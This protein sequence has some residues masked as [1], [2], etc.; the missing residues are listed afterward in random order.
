[1]GYG[2]ETF[3]V[4]NMLRTE[5]HLRSLKWAADLGSQQIHFSKSDRGD[6]HRH[7]DVI[8]E[9]IN[10]YTA[11]TI[12]ATKVREL[13]DRAPTS[14]LYALINVNYKSFDSNGWYGPPFDLNFDVAPDTDRDKYCLTV[15]AGT[16][17]HLFNQVNAFNVMHDLT[18]PDGVMIHIL[19]FIGSIDHGFFNY[20]PN[21]FSALAGANDYELLGQWLSPV[22]ETLL[23]EWNEQTAAA[24]CCS[25]RLSSKGG[26]LWLVSVMKKMKRGEFVMPFQGSY[27]EMV[28]TELTGRYQWTVEKPAGSAEEGA[29]LLKRKSLKQLTSKEMTREVIRRL[30]RRF[31][32]S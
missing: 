19:P 32:L 30:L 5:G 15:N 9:F 23:F 3:T 27:S 16:T 1:M 28:A 24:F 21:L 2:I 29:N 20:N 12:S 25:G 22:G 18:R 7:H 13:A 10:H 26:G 4:L 31:G 11:E 14:D 17:E 8:G 6:S